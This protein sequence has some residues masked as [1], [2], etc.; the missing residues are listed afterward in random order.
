MLVDKDGYK[1]IQQNIVKYAGDTIGRGE[2]DVF[3]KHMDSKLLDFTPTLMIYGAYNAGKSTLLN[4][5]FG[6]DE[7]AKTGDAPETKDIHEYEYNGY[8]IFDT[9]GLNAR[10]DDDIVT[11]EQLNK[12]EV[13]LFVLSNNG[14][15]EEEFVY[16]KISVVVKA[17]KPVI[18]VLNNKSGVELNSGLAIDLIDKVGANLRK[19]GDRN[20]ISNIENKVSL[21]MVNAKTAL[22]GKLEGKNLILKRSNILQLE[23]MIEELLE[24]AGSKEVI[25]TLNAYT[26]E[27]IGNIISK[28]DSQMD[29]AEVKKIEELITYLEKFKQSTEIKLKSIVSKKMPSFI[30]N[31]SS[32]L[33]SGDVEIDPYIQNTIEDINLQAVN[34]FKK[35]ESDLQT[36]IDSF[37]IEFKELNAEYIE[38]DIS[39]NIETPKEAP[40]RLKKAQDIIKNTIRDKEK[41]ENLAVNFLKRAKESLPKETMHGKGPVWMKKAAG[42]AAIGLTIAVEVYNVYSANKEHQEM[43]QAEKGRMLGARNSAKSIAND[44]ASSLFTSIDGMVVDTFNSL[45]ISFREESKKLNKGNDSLMT[46]KDGLRR[47]SNSLQS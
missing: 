6:E 14:S 27:F 32:K 39:N 30:E 22:K 42:K 7:K 9:P 44:I 29:D 23:E 2:L 33:L 24:A 35:V 8:T 26:Q 40:S 36:K 41:V 15:L 18:I 38:L 43:I 4:A 5:L 3:N 20:N 10:I 17:N 45:I 28:I 1:E 11:Q 25:N 13:I 37:A 47:L 31:V 46:K 19:I 12:S 21:C 34:I 16:E